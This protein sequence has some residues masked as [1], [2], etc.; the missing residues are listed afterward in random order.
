[1]ISLWHGDWFCRMSRQVIIFSSAKSLM[2]AYQKL[3]KWVKG[4][5]FF[6]T[7]RCYEK[8][9][10][11]LKSN[12][13]LINFKKKY[14]FYIFRWWFLIGKFICEYFVTCK[15]SLVQNPPFFYQ[16][17][18]ILMCLLVTLQ[19]ICTRMRSHNYNM[20][21]FKSRKGF[22]LVLRCAYK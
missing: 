14:Y 1:M 5:N 4:Y 10:V 13:S 11:C 15:I 6:F 12:Y 18:N 9:I 22:G 3:T 8:K 2:G 19:S 17:E 7:Y 21:S 20:R 16:E